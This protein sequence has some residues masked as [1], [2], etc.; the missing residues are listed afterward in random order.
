LRISSGTY[1]VTGT[2]G[3]PGAI[4]SNAANI[5]LTGA[6]AEILDTASST[7]ALSAIASNETIGALSLQSGQALTTATA[8][9]NA[10]KI[11]VGAAT[12]FN[13]GG[14]YTQTAGTTTVDGTITVPSGITLQKGSLVGK[15]TVA[16]AVTSTAATV[17]AG[18]SSTKPGTLVISGSYTQQAKGGLDIYVGG[19]AAGTFGDLAVSNGVSLGGTLTIKLVNGFMPVVGDTFT[20]LTGSAISGTFAT[21][22]GTGI[23]SSEHFEVS[24]SSTAVTLTV[25]S[26][27]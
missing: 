18:D 4:V 26:G 5:M 19:T 23:N 8:L 9:T 2:L 15:G 20:I 24:Y 12:S 16:A 11:T 25:V 21:V 7:N 22:K 27:S 14:S 6:S 17:T 13:L 10:G 1:A 3:L